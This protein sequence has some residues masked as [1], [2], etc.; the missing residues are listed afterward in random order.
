MPHILIKLGSI[1]ETKGMDDDDPI[2]IDLEPAQTSKA[3]QRRKTPSVRRVRP[4]APAE[5][6]LPSDED[7]NKQSC[8]GEWLLKAMRDPST[9]GD[10]AFTPWNKPEDLRTWGWVDAMNEGD[11][12]DS[13]QESDSD[14]ESNPNV[15]GGPTRAV[16][17][18]SQGRTFSYKH[19]NA[20]TGPELETGSSYPVSAWARGRRVLPYKYT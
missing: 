11:E 12:S 7:F 10:R 9:A 13:D 14:R 8:R 19:K 16:I 2:D 15:Y 5:V 18:N 1:D 6:E 4:R 3:V 20:Y 17:G